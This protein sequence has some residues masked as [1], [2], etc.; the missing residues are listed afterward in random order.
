MY[1]MNSRL[2]PPSVI[3]TATKKK[4]NLDS[5][6]QEVELYMKNIT[7]KF[8]KFEH[9]PPKTPFDPKKEEEQIKMLYPQ[10]KHDFIR[11]LTLI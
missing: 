10:V 11:L 3:K 2:Q 1:Q 7:D 9:A 5:I 4:N 6:N 8:G